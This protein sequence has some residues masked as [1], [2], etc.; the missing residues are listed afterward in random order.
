MMSHWQV[1]LYVL[2]MTSASQ[3]RAVSEFGKRAMP[4]AH[5]RVS[6]VYMTLYESSGRRMGRDGLEHGPV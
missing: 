4:S 6:W 1:T 5:I 3:D 2:L